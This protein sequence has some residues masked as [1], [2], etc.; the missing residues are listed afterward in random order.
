MP[1]T[2]HPHGASS[3]GIPL[4][5]SAILSVGNV[6]FVDSGHTNRAD[7]VG[8]GTDPN[9]PFA[10]LDFAIGRCTANNGDVILVAGGHAETVAT[11]AAIAC[12]VAGIH[13]IGLGEGAD[14]PVFSFSATD[15]TMTVSAASITIE[16]I[17]IKPSIDQ[18]VSP[19][20]VSADSA[21]L[22]SKA[23]PIVFEDASTTIELVRGILTT[24]SADNLTINT[25]YLGQTGGSHCV[26]AVRLVG[27]NGGRINVDFYGKASTAV[28]E[29]LTTA[30][31][32][33]E[34]TGTFY[35][36]GATT[37]AKNIVDTATGSTWGADIYDSAA[38]FKQTGG[39]AVALPA[40]ANLAGTQFVIQSTVVS[41]SIPNNT[42]TG[43]AITGAASG[44]VVV[45]QMIFETGTTGVAAPTNIEIS[46]DNVSGLT[47]AA[48]PH[49]LQAVSGLGANKTIVGTSVSGAKLPFT[50][51]SGK[52]VYID[53]DDAAGTGAGVLRITMI[54]RRVAAT[55]T[56]AASN[57]P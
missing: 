52:K 1:L 35:V 21:T 15:A 27:C 53:G 12:D 8:S 38:G 43:G 6:F 37:G 13:I 32:D 14:I 5:G 46:T 44:V 50:L 2:H 36:S 19:I 20:V 56:L 33:I 48:A 57:L 4:I 55:S 29:F 47:G 11:A 45:E 10:T 28:V 3:F 49:I 31:T 42:Q 7:A 25:R 40:T 30:C 54:C 23:A 34:V 9:K 24:A 26:N 39:S 17:R 41:S 18:V 22:G 51:E 16:N